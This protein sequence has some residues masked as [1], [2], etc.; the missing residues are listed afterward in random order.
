M[1]KACAVNLD[2]VQ[3]VSKGRVEGLLTTLSSPRMQMLRQ[4]LLF[5]QV[6]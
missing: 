1:P 6:C 4:S 3:T 5:A 2:H